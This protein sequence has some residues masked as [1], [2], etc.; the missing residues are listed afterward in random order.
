MTGDELRELFLRFFEGKGHKLFPSSSLVPHEDPTLLLTNAGM[1]Q[2]KPYFMGELAPPHPRPASCQKCF[3][4][5]DVESVGDLQHL[6]FFEMLGNFS[7]GDY[8]KKEAI[9]YTWEFVLEYLHLPREQLWIT[10]FL[11][12]DESFAY[13]QELE[14]PEERIVRHGEDNNFWGPAGDSGPC[15]PCTEIH[16]D[17]GEEFG[18]GRPDC[19]PGCD[20]DRYLELWNLVFTQYY[21]DK[22]GQR[23]LLPKKNVDT[24][25]GLERTAAVV[26][27]KRSAYE[28]DFFAPLIEKASELTGA[29]YGQDDKTTRA[30]RVIAEHGRAV[31]FLIADG[32]LPANDGRGYVLRRVLRRAVRYG[33][34][35]GLEQPFLTEL[36][37]TTI[38]HMGHV[39]PELVEN[40]NLI[41]NVIALEEERFEQTL[42]TGLVIL[43]EIMR[44]AKGGIISGGEAFRLYDTY[45]FPSELTAEIAA[46]NGFSVDLEGFEQ[47]MEQQRERARAVHKFALGEKRS[48]EAY[49]ALSGL[50]TE[51][52]GY[53]RLKD[54]S[55][56]IGLIADG[57]PSKE[58][59][60]GQDV[61]VITQSTPFY[62]EMGGQLGDAGDIH[63]L[64]EAGKIAI[65]D[66]MRPLPE[67]PKFI[68]H[69]GRVVEGRL[70]VDDWVSLEVD[71]ERRL[72]IARNHTATHLLH[73]ALR[74][75][76][77]KH[78]RQMG[79]LVAPERLRFDFSHHAPVS[80]EELDKIQQ[81]ANEKIRQDLIVES[82]IL[83]FDQA[84]AEGALAFFGEKYGD[85][86][87]VMTIKGA[88]EPEVFSAEL[89]GGT[90]ISRTGQIGML[91][92][93]SESSIGAG[94]R[95]IEAVTGR[96]AEE[97]IQERLF[98]LETV[99]HHLKAP[100]AEVPT[101]VADI[102]SQLDSE[103][104]RAA[105]LE[106]ELARR[107]AEALLQRVQ[108][109]DGIAVLAAE[110]SASNMEI[111]R[112]MGDWLKAKLGSAVIVL[113]AIWDDKPH[114]LTMVTQDLV[115]KGLNAAEIAKRVAQVTGG[116]GGG[117]SHLGQAGGKDKTKLAEA[118]HL[119]DK[120]VTKDL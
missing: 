20:C 14:V 49:G 78:V 93:T 46:E 52:T 100:V 44:Q 4:T 27:G 31:A 87:Q 21:Q 58:A 75:V 51:F 97:L 7:L 6:T 3:R 59:M 30:L 69:R 90:H 101:R 113:G 18:C 102:L 47:E 114:F 15:G 66:T 99:A 116:G 55:I 76:L 108:S 38:A 65:A 94:L 16:Y 43:D 107:A 68:V 106:Q 89:C 85:T 41:L 5:T 112:Q 72:D 32:I 19:V 83:P 9:A 77:G 13:W 86:V 24:G 12:D 98:A 64:K 48:A 54:T 17:F 103:Q 109:V 61:E 40:Q 80:K 22:D 74:Q 88:D 25:M 104:K 57:E 81:L 118:L 105:G 62:A 29:K 79:S 120:L 33:R 117:Q 115:T 73:A 119:V 39:Y 35:L 50:S 95:R 67:Y 96:G 92:V 45:G 36:A 23:T 71:A 84:I 63:N 34:L 91:Q 82:K 42:S 110:V 28:T 70:S 111:L 8:F 60:A 37:Q 26:Q 10:I 1:V 2:F 56:V 53:D 11:D